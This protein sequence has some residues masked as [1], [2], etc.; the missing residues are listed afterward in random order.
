MLPEIIHLETDSIITANVSRI[1]WGHDDV[2]KEAMPSGVTELTNNNKV[3][4]PA[5]AIVRFVGEVDSAHSLI[6][7]RSSEDFK[8]LKTAFNRP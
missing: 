8:T 7:D 3:V 2:P 4:S 1:E 5:V 6:I